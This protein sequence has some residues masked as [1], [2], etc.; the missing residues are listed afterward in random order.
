MLERIS[1]EDFDKIR[2]FSPYALPVCSNLL[3]VVMAGPEDLL[4][5]NDKDGLGITITE[6]SHISKRFRS[7]YYKAIL[8]D[9]LRQLELFGAL[10][11]RIET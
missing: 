8:P 3:T 10:D 5:Y 9:L 4:N 1:K 6:D 11:D 2:R 7:K